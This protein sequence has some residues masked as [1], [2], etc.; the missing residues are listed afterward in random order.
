M[1]R[2]FRSIWIWTASTLL[3]LTWVPLLG[4]IWLFDKKP[5]LVHTAR[6]FRMLGRIVGR[7]TPWVIH[8]DGAEHVDRNQV[9]VIVSNHQS[10]ADIP[11]ISFLK[12]DAKWLAKAELF[13][14]PVFG[15]MM[16]LSGDVPVERTS[17]QQAAR[18]LLRCGK[19]L[20]DR[21]SVIFFPE[22]SRSVDGNVQAF[23]AGAFSLALREQVPILPLVIHG[24]SR[25]LPRASWM[26][27]GNPE[28]WLRVLPP[29]S[30]EGKSIKQGGELCEEVR[31][32]IMAGLEELKGLES[33]A[34]A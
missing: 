15:W 1:F 32:R 17:P 11:L 14:V 20:R 9:Y 8:I 30:V 23:N 13:Q 3:V 6:W 4:L 22:G 33:A 34:K 7:V 12:L 19:Y 21:V 27:S 16:Q 28:I 29:V 10:L 24:T 31:S 18:A 25:A 5:A 2:F 26:F